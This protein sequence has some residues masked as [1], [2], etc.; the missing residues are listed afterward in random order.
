M[1]SP[2]NLQVDVVDE[3]LVKLNGQK[4]FVSYCI[5]V[6][7]GD[8]FWSLYYSEEHIKK[9]ARELLQP[10]ME[11]YLM[12]KAYNWFAPKQWNK[13][14]FKLLGNTLYYSDEMTSEPNIFGSA[15]R[16][17]DLEHAQVTPTYDLEKVVT[18][19]QIPNDIITMKAM[20]EIHQQNGKVAYLKAS[21]QGEMLRWVDAMKGEKPDSARRLIS[22][23]APLFTQTGSSALTSSKETKPPKPGRR[24]TQ[25][26]EV[27]GKNINAFL[28]NLCAIHQHS[29]TFRSFLLVSAY[30]GEEFPQYRL[31][32][33]AF[34]SADL[35][36]IK[37]L[38]GECGVP[39]IFSIGGKHSFIEACRLGRLRVVEYMFATE[40]ES[41]M[42]PLL[43]KTDNFEQTALHYACFSSL[44]LALLLINR[45]S[46]DKLVS[47]FGTW[48][49]LH[50][51][52]KAAKVVLPEQ[53]EIVKSMVQA[54]KKHINATDMVESYTPLHICARES[55]TSVALILLQ[56]N[57][58][59]DLVT[60]HGKTFLHLLV[61]NT[62]TKSHD[63]T[64]QVLHYL[65]HTAN[66]LRACTKQLEFMECY[67]NDARPAILCAI[68]KDPNS[69]H[70]ALLTKHYEALEDF[71]FKFLLNEIM[72]IYNQPS[73][74]NINM[75]NTSMFQSLCESIG[76]ACSQN[77][78]HHDI[79]TLITRFRSFYSQLEIFIREVKISEKQRS[80]FM[81]E[82]QKKTYNFIF[83]LF[84]KK[85]AAVDFV[86]NQYLEVYKNTAT[87]IG[88]G[89]SDDF[90]Q[91]VQNKEAQTG[92]QLGSR[93][94]A[95]ESPLVKRALGLL[96]SIPTIAKPSGKIHC[97]RE[98]LSMFECRGDEEFSLLSYLMV[99]VQSANIR[100]S[101]E[102]DYITTMMPPD[103]Y[104]MLL[105][106]IQMFFLSSWVH[107]I[108]EYQ[109]TKEGN[110][111][112]EEVSD[113]LQ[114]VLE[115]TLSLPSGPTDSLLLLAVFF[116]LSQDTKT[117][118][119]MG[120]FSRPFLS[121][122]HMFQI[123]QKLQLT[124]RDTNENGTIVF[125]GE[126]VPTAVF[127]KLTTSF[128]GMLTNE[129]KE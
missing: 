110:L 102:I 7:H 118:T 76:S 129:G 109:Q 119:L 67:D 6:T 26:E 29:E 40:P 116:F 126:D 45:S 41:E 90:W 81:D 82:V 13:R 63:M 58:S 24:L 57:A 104:S 47:M 101:A 3:R 114:I 62:S 5:K 72:F 70:V 46:A 71:K 19:S 78:Y 59:Y 98:I 44:E 43:Y 103:K 127:A 32:L 9:L 27:I 108:N 93:R 85:K 8:R 17:I 4:G 15:Y 111:L 30:T 73:S 34:D 105:K 121:H 80:D 18:D 124:I 66:S 69:P 79:S 48:T 52:A 122:P 61:Q 96:S 20:F 107:K 25:P 10:T 77:D 55:N 92:I 84:V 117:V 65:F 86:L 36:L 28:K 49:P 97:I 87:R 54:L 100:W 94:D 50:H 128:F 68:A 106:S 74:I 112:A 99:R 88:M 83:D 75:L 12:K 21:S 123:T 60:N 16:K 14:Y 35:T 23:S 64:A 115:F 95:Y 39:I 53:V 38:H 37:K 125:C 56:N 33:D 91:R 89:I 11:G 51:L 120:A 1:A 31:M 42:E 113:D 22:R 2:L